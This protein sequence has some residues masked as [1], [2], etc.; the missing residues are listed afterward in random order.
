M[1]ST[2]LPKCL[3]QFFLCS[4]NAMHVCRSCPVCYRMHLSN[5]NLS[6]CSKL[7]KRGL[8]SSSV[9]HSHYLMTITSFINPGKAA[10]RDI[11]RKMLHL[12]V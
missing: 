8:Y 9:V 12:H 6:M 3:A 5:I 10:S 1:Y 11:F 4:I 7:A 2:L